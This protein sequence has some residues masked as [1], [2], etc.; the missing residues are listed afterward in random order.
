MVDRSFIYLLGE[1]QSST[2]IVD[3]EASKTNEN[4]TF[5]IIADNFVAKNKGFKVKK[6]QKK[7]IIYLYLMIYDGQRLS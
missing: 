6:K 4:T 7:K 5:D 2:V 1:G 3:S